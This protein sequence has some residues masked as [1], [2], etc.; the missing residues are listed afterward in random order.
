MSRTTIENSSKPQKPI[1]IFNGKIKEI[2][3]YLE[4]YAKMQRS[5][6]TLPKSY[7][8]F[9][10]SDGEKIGRPDLKGI[11]TALKSEIKGLTKIVNDNFGPKRGSRKGTTKPG[12]GLLQPLVLREN[13]RKFL[14]EGDFGYVIPDDPKSG[15]LIDSIPLITEGI[16]NRTQLASLIK[17]Y[18]FVNELILPDKG[19][20]MRADKLMTETLGDAFRE[21]KQQRSFNEDKFGW[22][23]LNSLVSYL[24]VPYKDLEEETRLDYL[25][26][27]DPVTD[28]ENG[29]PIGSKT[30][31]ASTRLK[32]NNAYYKQALETENV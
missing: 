21:L 3:R 16:S 27:Y 22:T 17:T 28:N 30:K 29:S 5:I 11:L 23:D 25:S 32:Q 6:Y 7:D 4:E 19:G 26:I 10:F 9:Q 14:A 20:Y 24:S 18:C 8:A 13:V 15:D 2:N 31:E 1:T 12:I